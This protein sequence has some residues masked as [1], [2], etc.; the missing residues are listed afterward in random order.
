MQ[1]HSD[2]R[3][4]GETVDDST[5]SEAL[6]RS[7]SKEVEKRKAGTSRVVHEVIRLQG[8]DELNRPA[9][10]LAL[11][12]LAAGGAIT[13]SVFGEAAIKMRMGNVPSADLLAAFGYSIGFII[14]VM[15][16]LQLFTENTITA[17]LPLINNPNFHNLGRLG[18]LWTIVL[19]ANLAGTF[20]V[21]IG[22]ANGA[23]VSQGMQDEIRALATHL[24]ANS[25]RTVLLLGIPA[26]FL[27]ASVAWLLPSSRGSELWVIL[28]IT[29]LIAAGG[30]THVI[31]GSTEIWTSLLVGDIGIGAAIGGFLLP[32]L[33]G[34]IIGGTC[35]FALL[36]HG[37]VSAEL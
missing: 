20:V 23:I 24:L 31:A 25:P 36:A 13:A 1:P 21:A 7:E 14:V 32:V 15:G 19:L 35:L 6:T 5:P 12:G 17:V 10:S 26:G 29:W 18:R 28:V 11:S 37:Q 30:F 8:D 9:V 34:N 3:A 33:I 2:I 22:I 4:P 16:R 27:V